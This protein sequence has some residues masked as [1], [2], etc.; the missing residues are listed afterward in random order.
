[1]LFAFEPKQADAIK[2][3]FAKPDHYDIQILQVSS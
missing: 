3:R 1:M 2:E